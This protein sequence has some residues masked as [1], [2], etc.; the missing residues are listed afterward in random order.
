[1]GLDM[2]LT[3]K[4][5]VKNWDHQ[6]PEERHE[7]TVK[8]GGRL[9]NLGTVAYVEV[10]AGYWRKAN[11]VHNWFVQ[12]VQGGKDECQESYVSEEQLQELRAACQE[13]LAN[14]GKATDLLPPTAGFFFG[15][16]EVDSGYY[17]DLRDTVAIITEVLDRPDDLRGDIYYRASW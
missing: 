7:V 1:M 17:D 5:Y 8:K 12:K 10:E 11:A 6:K 16:T 2:Y 3:A 9:L 15:S 4:H 13:V 14:P